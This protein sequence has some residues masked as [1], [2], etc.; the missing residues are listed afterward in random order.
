M[1]VANMLTATQMGTQV[2]GP[3]QRIR[4]GW[5]VQTNVTEAHSAFSVPI[6]VPTTP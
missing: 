2:P 5:T 3:L 6:N 4:S 1:C